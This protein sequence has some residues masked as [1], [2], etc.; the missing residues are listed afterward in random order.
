[1]AQKLSDTEAAAAREAMAR[2]PAGWGLPGDV[3]TVGQARLVLRSL[4]LCP[5]RKDEGLRT[6]LARRGWAGP[7]TA[8]G[9]CDHRG[10]TQRGRAALEGALRRGP[11]A[12]GLP[13][14]RWTLATARALLRRLTGRQ[15]APVI[16]SALL[17]KLGYGS[18]QRMTP[19]SVS[20][21]GRRELRRR[22]ADLVGAGMPPY[23]AGA[24]LGI[25][26]HKCTPGV[27]ARKLREMG[28]EA[29][30]ASYRIG[31]PPRMAGA[32]LERAIAV[33]RSARARG[34]VGVPGGITG[35]AFLAEIRDATGE[36]FH[37]LSGQALYRRLMAESAA[38]EPRGAS[39][40]DGAEIQVGAGP[41]LG[42]H[43]AAALRAAVPV[44]PEDQRDAVVAH[45]L[46]HHAVAAPA[47]RIGVVVAHPHEGP[48]A[49]AADADGLVQ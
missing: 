23:R 48:P 33:A 22:F 26:A 9:L 1:M 20:G 7:I 2:G 39:G 17:R 44:A 12:A 45:V 41:E 27:W 30:I 6:W 36:R 21:D 16:A 29:F 15:W 46:D 4:G 8:G 13:G 47:G 28:R 43:A 49:Q 18:G 24:T 19:L 5:P 38:R 40:S 32:T 10:L 37:R 35:T 34:G 31:R 3:W 25:T 11:A 14:E 42:A